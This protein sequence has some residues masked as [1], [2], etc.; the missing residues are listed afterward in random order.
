[1]NGRRKAR[2]AETRG[3]S[4]VGGGQVGEEEEEEREDMLKEKEEG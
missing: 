3:R 4:G 1:M 2:E